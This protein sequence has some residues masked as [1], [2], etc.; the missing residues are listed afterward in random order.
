MRNGSWVGNVSMGT[1]L[2][3]GGLG[4][5]MRSLSVASFVCCCGMLCL[6]VVGSL[7]NSLSVYVYLR[8][9]NRQGILT[10]NRCA[11]IALIDCIREDSP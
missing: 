1:E 3:T 8:R 7:G 4:R 2:D 9:S 6:A 10:F 11:G 5:L